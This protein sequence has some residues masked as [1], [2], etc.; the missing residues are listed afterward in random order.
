MRSNRSRSLVRQKKPAPRSVRSPPL[1][2]TKSYVRLEKLS[3]TLERPAF[4]LFST[5]KA[6]QRVVL[7]AESTPPPIVLD[8]RIRYVAR[9]AHSALDCLK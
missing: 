8:T 2:T 7:R 6:P 9:S 3:L 5:Q 1:S 4:R